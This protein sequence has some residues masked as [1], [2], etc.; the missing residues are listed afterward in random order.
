MITYDAQARPGKFQRDV[1]GGVWSLTVRRWRCSGGTPNAL[2]APVL[3]SLGHGP[4]AAACLCLVSLRSVLFHVA[5]NS[6]G[7]RPCDTQVNDGM[8]TSFGG[9][10]LS[11]FFG[12]RCVR[13]QSSDDAATR[14][15]RGTVSVARRRSSLTR[16]SRATKYVAVHRARVN[17]VRRVT[18]AARLCGRASSSRRRSR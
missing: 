6:D 12:M 15:H 5:F 14:P 9:V 17:R 4:L 18:V 11:I 1:R 10:G 3:A 16:K 8:F 2:A 7:R 13:P